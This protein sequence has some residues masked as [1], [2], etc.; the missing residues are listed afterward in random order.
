MSDTL[1]PGLESFY[2]SF[3]CAF[4]GNPRG[5]RLPE[6]SEFN[7]YFASIITRQVTY[8]YPSLEISL[9]FKFNRDACPS[10]CHLQLV[11]DFRCKKA[12][13]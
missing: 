6:A 13:F 9:G 2:F 10:V 4:C 3:I 1:N 8:C 7:P 5:K 11:P 12:Y